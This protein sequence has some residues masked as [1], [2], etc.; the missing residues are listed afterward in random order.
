MGRSGAVR[1][2][3]PF[4][5]RRSVEYCSSD[6]VYSHVKH[7]YPVRESE[8]PRRSQTI[9][10]SDVEYVDADGDVEKKKCKGSC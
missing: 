10:L 3:G 4:A 8:N 7:D 6:D 5:A 2:V 1:Y 9:G